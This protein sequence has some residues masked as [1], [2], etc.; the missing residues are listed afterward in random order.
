VRDTHTI[1]GTSIIIGTRNRPEM[2][3]ETVESILVGDVVPDEI[4][5]VDQSDV[6]RELPIDGA[7]ERGCAIRHIHTSFAGL[8]RANNLGIS[9]ARNEL[10]VFTH[11]DVRVTHEWFATLRAALIEGGPRMVVTGRILASEEAGSGFAPTLSVSEKASEYRGRIPFDVLKPLNM[12]LYRTTALTVGGFDE[13]LGPGTSFPGAEDSDLGF[14]LLEHGY[15]IRYVPVALLYHRAWRPWREYLPLR[16]RYGVAQGAFYAKHLSIRDRHMLRRIVSDLNHRT[17]RFVRRFPREGVPAL[18][19]PVFLAGN[20]V[21][22]IRWWARHRAGVHA[23][24]RSNTTAQ[25]AL[26]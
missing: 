9:Q 4:V 20:L 16:W 21:G 3:Y 15:T 6:L 7:A 2:L 24:D 19:D 23:A 5:I 10:L 1:H 25:G 12:G 14:R 17:R 8:S 13:R 11:D 18:R 22:A 26:R